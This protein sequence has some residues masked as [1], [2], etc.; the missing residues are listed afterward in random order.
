MC[1][2]GDGRYCNA[3]KAGAASTNVEQSHLRVALFVEPK[4][5]VAMKT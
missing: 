1:S 5:I 3:G 2:T 4:I